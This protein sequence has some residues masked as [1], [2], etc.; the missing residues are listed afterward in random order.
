MSEIGGNMRRGETLFESLLVLSLLALI[1]LGLI[2][3]IKVFGW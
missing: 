3:L 1:P 2:I